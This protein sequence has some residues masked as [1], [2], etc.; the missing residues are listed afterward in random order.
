MK[1][2]INYLLAGFALLAV[3]SCTSESPDSSP[4]DTSNTNNDGLELERTA[5]PVAETG[6]I[7]SID[8]TPSR[9]NQ[10][11]YAQP[12][13]TS[14]NDGGGY[15]DSCSFSAQAHSIVVAEVGSS[16]IH[17]DCPLLYTDVWQ[18]F[19]VEVKDVVA[20]YEVPARV[21]VHGFA[22]GHGPTEP[23]ELRVLSLRRTTEGWFAIS[24]I[25]IYDRA[26]HVDRTS[27]AT[28]GL[29]EAKSDLRGTMEARFANY[30]DFETCRNI[31]RWQG[32]DEFLEAIHRPAENCESSD[33]PD[34]RPGLPP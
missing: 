4:P 25:A 15:V 8:S 13:W 29:P 12:H 9:I 2:N 21:N 31:G 32:D 30:H 14:N 19:S 10:W 24:S 22:Q 23:G 1:Q 5:P 33:Q 17:S 16:T 34:E 6:D 11:A 3:V 27:H 20:G 28:V 26:V 18:E 7:V